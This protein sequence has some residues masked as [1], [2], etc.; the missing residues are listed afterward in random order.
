M[1][2][3]ANY[4]A[5]HQPQL[6]H[7]HIGRLTPM[8]EQL[9]TTDKLKKSAKRQPGGSAYLCQT[10]PAQRVKIRSSPLLKPEESHGAH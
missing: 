8:P 10:Y 9:L 5:S 3:V 2:W 6:L 4:V 7:D 1:L